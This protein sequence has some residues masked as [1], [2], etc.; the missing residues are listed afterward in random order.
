MEN[1]LLRIA[2]VL[3]AAAVGRAQTLEEK[4]ERKLAK[5]FVENVAWVQEYDAALAKAKESGR[6]VFAYFSR[7]YAP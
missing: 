6:I 1:R 7:S 3:L 5:P 2:V 4:L